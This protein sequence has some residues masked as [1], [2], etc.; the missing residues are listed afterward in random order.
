[1]TNRAAFIAGLRALADYLED[2]PV[3]PIP[4]HEVRFHVFPGIEAAD[5]NQDV[6]EVLRGVMLSS[7]GWRKILDE[8]YYSLEQS[9]GPVT[10]GIV[11][12]QDQGPFDYSL[13]PDEV[14]EE[15]A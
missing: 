8:D 9:F 13:T 4:A 5:R 1:M 11:V 6:R 2:S 12:D 15:E 3:V 10:F 14:Y 7:R